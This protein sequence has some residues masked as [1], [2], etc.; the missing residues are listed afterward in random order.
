MENKGK[1]VVYKDGSYHYHEDG[2]TWEFEADP[3]YLVTIDVSDQHL[4]EISYKNLN[5]VFKEIPQFKG[6]SEQ[7]EN[8]IRI[9]K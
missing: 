7:L 9:R 5:T 2:I 4:E 8:L 1:I 3:G 6:T